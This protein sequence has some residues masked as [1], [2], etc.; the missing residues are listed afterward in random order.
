ML[1]ALPQV[2]VMG[3]TTGGG[4][5]VPLGWELPNGWFFNYSNSITYMPDGFIIEDGIPPDVQLDITPEDMAAGR[6]TIL[7]A[8][9]ARLR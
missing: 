4:G 6:D 8:A 9:L 5:G 7:E 1:K 2:T 3:A